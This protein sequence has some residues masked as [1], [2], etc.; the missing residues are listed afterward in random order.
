MTSQFSFCPFPSLHDTPQKLCYSPSGVC[1]SQRQYLFPLHLYQEKKLKRKASFFDLLDDEL[2]VSDFKSSVQTL[3]T[4]LD[5]VENNQ[6][7]TPS[8]GKT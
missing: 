1:F 2:V 7:N 3:M 5:Q 4:T 8:I 6:E